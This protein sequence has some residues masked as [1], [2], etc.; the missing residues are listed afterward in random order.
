MR[1]L[2]VSSANVI[3]GGSIALLNII[4][5]VTAE[6]H[7][8]IVAATRDEGA[9]PEI[10]ENMGCKVIICSHRL[11]VY[12]T[13]KN[14]A[15]YLPRLIKTI[16]DNHVGRKEIRSIIEQYHPDIV[17][18]NVG[19][20][21]AAADVC[22]EMNI[23]HVWH[24]REYQDLDF[25]MTFL[26]CKDSFLR[27][28]HAKG[29]YNICITKGV[30]EHHKCRKGIDRVIYDGVFNEADIPS[31]IHQ[32][33]DDYILFA[34]RIEEAKG[35]YDL[36]LAY[37][38]FHKEFPCTKLKVAGRYNAQ[39]KYYRK[40]VDFIKSNS[41]EGDV[42]IL[43]ERKDVYELMS[44][45]RMLVVPSRFEGFGFITAEAMLNG[46]TV[47]GRNTAGTKEQFDKGVE[48]TGTEIGFRFNN[49]EEMLTAMKQAMQVS[50]DKMVLNA[51]KTV[52]SHYTT[53]ENVRQIIDFYKE[54]TKQG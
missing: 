20:L 5:G 3:G 13:K 4:R 33:K 11:S 42:E 29:N 47:V 26:P 24:L 34:G 1:I 38:E 51:K 8:V 46:C 53:E 45:A 9:L 54:I 19:P 2:Y 50:T 22:R 32:E 31:S 39:S 25:G 41:L 18:T 10:L 52:V 28:I 36:L 37:L 44:R 17:H 12:P 14:V 40:C 43:G 30:F 48:Y 7:E 16:W 15:G 35:L 6:G 49:N 27:K 23:N 21:D